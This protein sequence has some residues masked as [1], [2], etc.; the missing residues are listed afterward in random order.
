MNMK[1]FSSWQTASKSLF[2][3]QIDGCSDPAFCWTFDHFDAS[4]TRILSLKRE[5]ESIRVCTLTFWHCFKCSSK[6]LTVNCYLLEVKCSALW[7]QE[8]RMPLEENCLREHENSNRESWMK[9]AHPKP[10]DALW[11]LCLNS[12]LTWFSL[13]FCLNFVLD[14]LNGTLSLFLFKLPLQ[15]LLHQDTIGFDRH[16][17]SSKWYNL[18]GKQKGGFNPLNFLSVLMF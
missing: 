6:V 5:R 2:L 9:N 18:N 1:L 12:N 13:D 7:L 17:L 4:S 8:N 16:K 3:A 10:K 15:K 11:V 14:R